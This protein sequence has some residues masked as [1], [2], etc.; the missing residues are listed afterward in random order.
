MG[1]HA[2]RAAAA[3]EIEDGVQDLPLRVGYRAAS[4]FGVGHQMFDQ[5]PFFVT[6][7]VFKKL[8]IA[9]YG[10]LPLEAWHPDNRTRP[11]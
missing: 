3:Q 10:G 6:Q 11:T 7:R 4:W 9:K 1:Q 8:A 5:V 2:P